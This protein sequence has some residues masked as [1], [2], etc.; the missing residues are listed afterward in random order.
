MDN[1]FQLGQEVGVILGVKTHLILMSAF[2][3]FL[4][5]RNIGHIESKE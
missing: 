1:P 3:R 5:H 4:T 2:T